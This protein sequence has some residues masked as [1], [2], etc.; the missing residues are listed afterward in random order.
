[1]N[2][3]NCNDS[4]IDNCANGSIRLTG[5]SMRSEGVVEICLDGVWGTIPHSF[6]PTF[7]EVVCRQLGFPWQCKY[8]ITCSLLKACRYYI[9]FLYYNKIRGENFF[10]E[11]KKM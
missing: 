5:G 1:M 3:N 11:M 6:F 8:G 2:F 9:S 7:A 10:C 4:A